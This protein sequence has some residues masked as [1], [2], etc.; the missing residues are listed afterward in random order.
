M[1]T[2]MSVQVQHQEPTVEIQPGEPRAEIQPSKDSL[3]DTIR[4]LSHK[5]P[6]GATG[7]WHFA[8][9][10]PR[11]AMRSPKSETIASSIAGAVALGLATGGVLLAWKASDKLI[12]PE[13]GLAAQ[14]G[15]WAVVAVLLIGAGVAASAAFG[16]RPLHL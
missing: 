1:E 10:A 12:A 8:I 15:A 3:L 4:G 13:T 11:W 6:N 16:S 2:D 7:H 14:I 9:T 5:I